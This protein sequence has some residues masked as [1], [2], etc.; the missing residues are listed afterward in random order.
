M[1]QFVG[2]STSCLSISMIV[3]APPGTCIG[4]VKYDNKL[5]F[6]R[7]FSIVNSDD[8]TVLK[9]T[10]SAGQIFSVEVDFKVYNHSRQ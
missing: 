8:E 2:N 5:T 10:R 9:I 4:G 3:E 7:W 1:A 6:Q